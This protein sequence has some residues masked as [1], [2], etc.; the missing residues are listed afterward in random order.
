MRGVFFRVCE[1]ECEMRGVEC[2]SRRSVCSVCSEHDLLLAAKID[3][4]LINNPNPQRSVVRK[5]LQR[6]KSPEAPTTTANTDTADALRSCLSEMQEPRAKQRDKTEQKTRAKSF[7]VGAHRD[8][9]AAEAPAAAA[10]AAAPAD[11]KAPARTFKSVCVFSGSS[12]GNSPIYAEV[13]ACVRARIRIG[14]RARASWCA[15][16]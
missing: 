15:L 12:S 4:A 2:G 14:A 11:Q 3:A 1:R 6:N 13:R 8:N 5:N 7:V 16:S 9:M 10:A